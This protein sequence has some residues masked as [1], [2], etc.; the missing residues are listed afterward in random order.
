MFVGLAKPPLDDGD[1]GTPLRVLDTDGDLDSISDPRRRRG[2]AL[3]YMS[4]GDVRC[5]KA[6]ERDGGAI[7][8]EEV[9]GRYVNVIWTQSRSVSCYKKTEG[10]RTVSLTSVLYLVWEKSM[11]LEKSMS[12]HH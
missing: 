12:S 2:V 8:G 3:V 9:L 5:G 4:L 6:G 7:P 10:R 1:N 11:N